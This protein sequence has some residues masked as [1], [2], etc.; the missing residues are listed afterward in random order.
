LPAEVLLNLA[1][2]WPVY[3]LVRK[4]FPPVD[5]SERAFEVQLLG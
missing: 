5:P 1:L 2:T 3:R 4:L